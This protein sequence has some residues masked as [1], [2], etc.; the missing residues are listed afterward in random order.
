[1]V[2]DA[3]HPFGDGARRAK[4]IQRW[5]ERL[6]IKIANPRFA[7]LANF[8]DPNNYSYGKTGDGALA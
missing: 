2:C 3:S 1:L 6:K 8:V 7:S 4:V 5:I